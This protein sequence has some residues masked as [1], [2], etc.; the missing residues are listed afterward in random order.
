MALTPVIKE[1]A[2]KKQYPFMYEHFVL[3]TQTDLYLFLEKNGPTVEAIRFGFAVAKYGHPNDEVRGG[4]PLFKHG[5][6]FYGLY[7]V[8]NSPWID[9]VKISNRVHPQHSD[10]LFDRDRHFIACFKDVT[11]EVICTEMEEVQLAEIEILAIVT[12]E[13]QYLEA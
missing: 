10:S 12:T 11:L 5:L 8:T 6:G 4:H 3:A 13:L 7:E 1:V 9:E 2:L